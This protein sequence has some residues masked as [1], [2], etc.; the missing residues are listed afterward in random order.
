MW[1]HTLGCARSGAPAGGWRGEAARRWPAVIVFLSSLIDL[2]LLVYWPL[3][4]AI[5]HRALRAF[6]LRVPVGI[7]LFCGLQESTIALHHVRSYGTEGRPRREGQVCNAFA[8]PVLCKHVASICWLPS[9]GWQTGIHLWPSTNQ[10]VVVPRPLCPTVLVF[11]LCV[12]STVPFCPAC[13]CRL[14]LRYMSTLCSGGQTFKIC[15]S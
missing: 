13:S 2:W 8:A 5:V 3:L 4:H 10:P 12:R 7:F 14:P 9:S 1:V 15:R 11:Y 6:F